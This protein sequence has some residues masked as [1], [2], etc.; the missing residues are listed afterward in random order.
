MMNRTTFF[1]GFTIMAAA[2]GLLVYS[3]NTNKEID[4][5]RDEKWSLKYEVQNQM[6]KNAQLEGENERLEAEMQQ[7]NSLMDTKQVEL[8]S[9]YMAIIKQLNED[10]EHWSV[11]KLATRDSIQLYQSRLKKVLEIVSAEYI[12]LASSEE[13]KLKRKNK[14]LYERLISI[15]DKYLERA[16]EID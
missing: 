8:D 4:N 10:K 1:G 11:E 15:S 14:E 12:A 9:S 2:I 5:L 16:D 13:Y 7:F 3:F 6:K